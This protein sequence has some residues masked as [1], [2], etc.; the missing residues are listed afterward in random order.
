MDDELA[1][2]QFLIDKKSEKIGAVEEVLNAQLTAA[3]ESVNELGE[4]YRADLENF[5]DA[6]S[7]K[8]AIREKI[9]KN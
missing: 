6:E 4:S 9:K 1:L 2:E 3:Q 8:L 7:A 5:S